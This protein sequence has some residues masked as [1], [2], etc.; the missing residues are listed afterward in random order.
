MKNLILLALLIGMMGCASQS[1]SD[2]MFRDTTVD[3]P[4]IVTIDNCEYIQ[5]HVREHDA[6]THKGNCKNPIHIHNGGSHE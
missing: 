1:S 3:D 6:I 4:M 5:Y 2:Q